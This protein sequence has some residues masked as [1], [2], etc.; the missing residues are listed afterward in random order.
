MALRSIHASTTRGAVATNSRGRHVL[1]GACHWASFGPCALEHEHHACNL[2]LFSHS[3]TAL[4]ELL[5]DVNRVDAV[6]QDD[7][8]RRDS[9]FGIISD[10]DNHTIAVWSE[11]YDAPRLVIAKYAP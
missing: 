2:V 1:R 10:A 3:T 4:A 6:R 5:L 8:M 7:L 9:A 11:Y